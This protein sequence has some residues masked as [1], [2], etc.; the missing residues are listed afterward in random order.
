[1]SRVYLAIIL[2]KEGAVMPPPAPSFDGVI[3]YYYTDGDAYYFSEG[4]FF[5][6]P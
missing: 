4:D 6:T 2:R 1:M 3:M 5:Y